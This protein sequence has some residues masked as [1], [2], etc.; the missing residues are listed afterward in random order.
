MTPALEWFEVKDALYG[1]PGWSLHVGVTHR[2]LEAGEAPEVRIYE[3]VINTGQREIPLQLNELP[4]LT[5]L[6]YAVAEI[7][8]DR[9]T[10]HARYL[11]EAS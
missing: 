10:E 1:V 9:D 2:Y 7:I 5:E 3:A 8:E 11:A 6:E 4:T